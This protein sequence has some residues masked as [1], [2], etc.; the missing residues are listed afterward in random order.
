MIWAEDRCGQLWCDQ[1][2]PGCRPIVDLVAFMSDSL[3][4][5]H[6]GIFLTK[7]VV[8]MPQACLLFL[9]F[10][11]PDSGKISSLV[12]ELFILWGK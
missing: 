12:C 5:L 3:G 7:S 4:R 8:T 1:S 6:L 2:L 11:S 10:F 9:S